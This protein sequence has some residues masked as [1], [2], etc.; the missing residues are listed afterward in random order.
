MALDFIG[1]LRKLAMLVGLAGV[2]IVIGLCLGIWAAHASDLALGDS[3]GRGTGDAM[4]AA[5]VP[6]T[7]RAVISGGSCRIAKFAALRK[8][9]DRVVVSAGIND[10]G[11]CVAAIRAKLKASLVVW[12]LPADINPGRAA[13]LAAMQPGDKSVSYACPGSGCSKSNFHPRSYAE[14]ADEVLRLWQTTAMMDPSQPASA[15]SATRPVS[16]GR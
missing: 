12:I 13:V 2:I 9:W 5:K 8:T 7:V 3:I 14:V 11:Q 4:R 10:S 1:Y 15:T 16:R 6:V